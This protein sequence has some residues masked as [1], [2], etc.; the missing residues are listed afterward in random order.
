MKKT[1]TLFAA[2]ALCTGSLFA[3]SVVFLQ[4]GEQLANNAEITVT[5]AAND[6]IWGLSIESGLRLNNTTSSQLPVTITQTVIE[7]PTSGSLSVCCS[8][9]CYAPSVE[10]WTNQGTAPAGLDNGSHFMF[11]F[12]EE[13]TYTSCKV[14]YEVYSSSSDKS[15]VTV[16]YQYGGA[17]IGNVNNSGVSVYNLNGQ[18][19][20]KLNRLS[21]NTQLVVYN[22]TGQVVGQYTPNAETFVLPVTLTNGIYIYALKENGKIISSGK[23]VKH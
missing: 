13:G 11:I 9:N 7:P 17:G 23:Y 3:Q 2:I 12:L 16:N 20:F 14:K 8:G 4:N 19:C 18:T 10:N 1:V 21:A 15:T 5:E 22:I 6:P